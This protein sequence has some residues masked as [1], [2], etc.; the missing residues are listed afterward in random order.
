MVSR[1]LVGIFCE[2]NCLDLFY[3][4]V[5][6]SLGVAS[7]LLARPEAR[8]YLLPRWLTEEDRRVVW[9]RGAVCRTELD[10]RTVS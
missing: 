8:F 5:R 6:G 10:R 2:Y 4:L 7:L 1:R 9:L 3:L